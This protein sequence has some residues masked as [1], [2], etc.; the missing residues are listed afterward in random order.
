MS[1]QMIVPIMLF[2]VVTGSMIVILRWFLKRIR[3]IEHDRWGDK[4][5]VN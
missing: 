5:D 2:M 4:K 3:K 1:L